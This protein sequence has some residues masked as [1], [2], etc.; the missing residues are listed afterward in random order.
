M[1][2]AGRDCNDGKR[3]VRNREGKERTSLEV[4]AQALGLKAR[5]GVDQ[6]DRAQQQAPCKEYT[7]HEAQNRSGWPVHCNLCAI[8]TR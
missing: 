4:L 1:S 3:L 8:D 5:A 7:P 2:G 6:S